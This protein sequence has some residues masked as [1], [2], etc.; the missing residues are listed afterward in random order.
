MFDY[1]GEDNLRASV[2][3]QAMMEKV[4]ADAVFLED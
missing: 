2:L 3:W 1:Y 4:A